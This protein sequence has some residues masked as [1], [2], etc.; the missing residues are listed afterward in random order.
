M[1]DN[2]SFSAPCGTVRGLHFQ[3]PP[4]AQSKLVRVLRGRILDVAVDTLVEIAAMHQLEERR[5]EALS[6]ADRDRLQLD[7]AEHDDQQRGGVLSAEICHNALQREHRQGFRRW[8]G[9]RRLVLSGAGLGGILGRGGRR[10]RRCRA[11]SVSRPPRRVRAGG[12]RL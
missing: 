8:L 11:Q 12:P 4:R 3:V 6:A 10:P 9:V 7:A 5:P 2:D 1:Q